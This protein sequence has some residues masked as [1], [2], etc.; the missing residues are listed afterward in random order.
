MNKHALHWLRSSAC[1]VIG[2][3]VISLSGC[4]NQSVPANTNDPIQR[5]DFLLNTFVDIKIYDSKDTTILDDAMAICKD[6]EDRFS[7]TLEGSEVYRLNHR[8]EDEQLLDEVF[9][10][11][12]LEQ[13]DEET[14]ATVN[15]FFENSLNISETA[16]KLYIHRNT[17]VY[18]LEKLQKTTGLDV[19]VF[20]DALTFKIALM[21]AKH[22]KSMQ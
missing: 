5:T 15:T 3:A 22:M 4:G 2:M 10:E 11:D 14:L 20:D 9:A 21:V 12:A 19:K 17:L 16:R 13:L 6:L 8:T 1:A 18:R 7:R